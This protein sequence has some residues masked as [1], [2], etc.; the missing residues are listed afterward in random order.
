M[1]KIDFENVINNVSDKYVEEAASF[2]PKRKAGLR[3]VALAACIAIIVTSVPFAFILN[4]E[5][6]AEHKHET[7]HTE[8]GDITDIPKSFGDIVLENGSLKLNTIMLSHGKINKES[9]L[10]QKYVYDYT[11]I[12]EESEL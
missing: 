3:W 7:D 1:K 12:D 11:P 9:T 2:V 10:S 4:R 8:Q 5:D 6:D